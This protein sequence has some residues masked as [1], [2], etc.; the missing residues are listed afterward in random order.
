MSDLKKPKQ[1]YQVMVAGDQLK[2]K[3]YQFDDPVPL[4]RQILEVAG[5]DADGDASLFTIVE[6]G[7]FEDVRLDE[8]V[9]LRKRGVERFV[10]FHGDRLFS[11]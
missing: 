2:F 11:V 5:Y 8:Q 6:N 3:P 4:G 10:A 9:D 7:D 1:G